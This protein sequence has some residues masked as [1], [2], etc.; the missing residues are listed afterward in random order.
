MVTAV[1]STIVAFKTPLNSAI[2]TP[3]PEAMVPENVTVTVVPDEP[4]DTTPCHISNPIDP[5]AIDEL[6]ILVQVVFVEAM[7][8][9]VRAVEEPRLD[10]TQAMRVLPFAAAVIVGV[11]GEVVPV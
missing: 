2:E 3:A 11:R 5:L 7:E 6:V 9:T 8:E 1:A 4:P 10:A